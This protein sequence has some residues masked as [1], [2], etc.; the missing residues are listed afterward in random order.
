MRVSVNGGEI[1]KQ[2][3]ISPLLSS[4]ITKIVSIKTVKMKI[5]GDGEGGVDE[6]N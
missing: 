6:E 5:T 1:R 4:L 3:R 2:G